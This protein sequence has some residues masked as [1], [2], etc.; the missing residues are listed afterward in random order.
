MPDS[1]GQ[2]TDKDTAINHIEIEQRR[3]D[4]SDLG[5]V[6]RGFHSELHRAD[7][8]EAKFRRLF[9]FAKPQDTSI[10]PADRDDTSQPMEKTK[11]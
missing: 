11:R 7:N 1:P 6:N 4:C 10:R 5:T 9:G 8:T 2:R 3:E